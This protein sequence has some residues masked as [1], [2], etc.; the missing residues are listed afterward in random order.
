[1]R[2][3]IDA[4]Q[5]A[6]GADV[7]PCWYAQPDFSLGHSWADGLDDDGRPRCAGCLE[8]EEQRVSGSD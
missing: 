8:W 1:M 2:D 4:L 6:I 7:V 3:E 5:E